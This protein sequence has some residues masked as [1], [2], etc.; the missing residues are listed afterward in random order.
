MKPLLNRVLLLLI[1]SCRIAR[2]H[3]QPEQTLSINVGRLDE[4]L[5][6]STSGQ[7]AGSFNVRMIFVVVM[8][9]GEGAALKMH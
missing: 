2:S 9:V 1:L 8:V 5:G 3:F 4:G 6:V 7:T